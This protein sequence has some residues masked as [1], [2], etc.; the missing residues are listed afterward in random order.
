MSIVHSTTF[1]KEALDKVKAAAEAATEVDG[2]IG[3]RI[4]GGGDT[5]I[6]LLEVADHATFDRIGQHPGAA[7]VS[8]ELWEA[9]P[10]QDHAFLHVLN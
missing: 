2:V 10:P 1:P 6:L 8:T 7:S 4:L 3:Y 9:F 5:I